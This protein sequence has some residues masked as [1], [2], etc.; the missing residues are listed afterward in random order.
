MMLKPQLSCCFGT[1]NIEVVYYNSRD[2]NA[3]CKSKNSMA[4]ALFVKSKKEFFVLI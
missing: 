1:H 2:F 3:D 4:A